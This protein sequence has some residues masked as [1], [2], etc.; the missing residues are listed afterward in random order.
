MRNTTIL[1][2]AKINFS[3]RE[4]LCPK[5]LSPWKLMVILDIVNQVRE[6]TLT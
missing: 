1:S 4:S 6:E 3:T 5:N 2:L